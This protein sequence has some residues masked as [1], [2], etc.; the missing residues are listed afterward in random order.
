[1]DPKAP[2]G[3]VGPARPWLHHETEVRRLDVLAIEHAVSVLPRHE[4][5][6]KRA[7][8]VPMHREDL[9]WQVVHG[10]NGFRDFRRACVAPLADIHCDE[11]AL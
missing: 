2:S 4:V 7:V 3:G 6:E 10:A 9:G 8:A 11:R 5:E 1:M